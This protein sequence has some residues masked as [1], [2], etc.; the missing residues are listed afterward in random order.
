MSKQTATMNIV[1]VFIL[2]TNSHY[3]YKVVSI[4]K[5]KYFKKELIKV[6]DDDIRLLQNEYN[7]YNDLKEFPFIPKILEFNKEK[8][9]ILYEY[10]DGI[11][12]LGKNFYEKE[13]IYKFLIDLCTILEFVHS[14]NIIHC[15]IKFS[16]ILISKEGKM[17]LIDWG[18]SSYIGEIVDF[19]TIKYCPLEQIHKE[20]ANVSFDIYAFGIMMYQ[21]FTG[22]DPFYAMKKEKIIEK[23]KNLKL[24]IVN[25]ALGAPKVLDEI[26][27]KTLSSDENEKYKSMHELKED[28]KKISTCF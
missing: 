13:N 18:I 5:K 17:Y 12:M 23:K 1:K 3:Q 15:D 16:N 8:N 28:L 2:N 19:G 22:E 27:K 10:I 24:S 9:Y 20:K 25:H 26:L 4:D 14:K 6:N 11:S 21:L 7:K